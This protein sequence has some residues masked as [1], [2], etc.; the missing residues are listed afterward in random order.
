MKSIVFTLAGVFCIGLCNAQGLKVALTAGGGFSYVNV[1]H[2]VGEYSSIF[3]PNAAA[4]LN[5]PMAK[6][7]VLFETGIG[8]EMKGFGSIT[9]FLKDNRTGK[10]EFDSKTQYH[11]LKIPLLVSYRLL[12]KDNGT[13]WLGAGMDYGFMMYATVSEMR[14]SY[15]GNKLD[16]KRKYT[17]HPKSALLPSDSYLPQTNTAAL[18]KF[19][20][21]VKFQLTYWW[22][23]RYCIQLFHEYS[24]Y[25]HN[26]YTNGQTVMHLQYTGMSVGFLF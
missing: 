10:N 20:P 21:T 25:D 8:Y 11:Y 17:Y 14:S 12:K 9:S 7:K 22:D 5:V 15:T 6:G 23:Q 16:Y 26:I 4:R 1:K 19:D 2:P 18:Y 3:C 13:L 24:L